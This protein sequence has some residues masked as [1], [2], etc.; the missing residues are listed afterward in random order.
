MKTFI[1]CDYCGSAGSV[2]FNMCQVCLKDHAGAADRHGGKLR[3][4]ALAAEVDRI[5]ADRAPV[6]PPA[7]TR[8]S[9]PH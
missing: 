6:R 4:T 8:G 5:I 2:E 3:V 7:F 9:R 1:D